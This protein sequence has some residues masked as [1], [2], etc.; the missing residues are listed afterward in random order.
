MCPNL[1]TESDMASLEKRSNFFRVVF[2]YQGRRYSYSLGTGNRP[3]AEE[4]RGGIE[5]TLMRIE[6]NLLKVPA[7]LD[8]VTFV[9]NDGQVV[10]P[11]SSTDSALVTLREFCDQY[12]DAHSSGAVE[13][14]SLATIRIHLAHIADTLGD[15]FPIRNLLAP[16]LQKHIT[17]R[18][19]KKGLGGKPLSPTTIRKEM[20]SFRA[21]WNWA[22]HMGIVGTVFPNKGLVFPKLEE[23]PPFMTW[24]E[25]ERRIAKCSPQDRVRADLWDALFL[26]R[27]EVDELLEHVRTHVKHPWIYPMFVFAA[28]T[29]ARRSEMIRAEIDDVDFDG[30]T[31]LIREKK[32]TRGRLTTRRVPL[33]PQLRTVLKDWLGHGFEGNNLFCQFS[34]VKH[35]RTIREKPTPITRDEAHDHFKRT[36][37]GSKWEVIRGW[38]VLRHSFAK[39]DYGGFSGVKTDRAAYGTLRNTKPRTPPRSGL[40]GRSFR[41][42]TS[43]AAV[44]NFQAKGLRNISPVP[45]VLSLCSGHHIR[46]ALSASTLPLSPVPERPGTRIRLARL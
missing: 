23:K 26:I 28:H 12:L 9:K 31:L 2:M 29:G 3:D 44:H 1:L 8:I 30:N 32:R 38:H 13:P 27:A 19:S 18:S 33:L 37:A 20:A 46:L 6:Q 5:K 42:W 45:F 15:R 39:G 7:G 40:N 10:E 43:N 11:V 35:S 36:L 22:V 21:A 14:S 25:I 24:S 17:R 41:R 16:D 4:L 34:T